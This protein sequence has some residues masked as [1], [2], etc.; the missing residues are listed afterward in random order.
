MQ[1]RQRVA[2]I[3]WVFV[4]FFLLHWI[5]GFLSCAKQSIL[6]L[7]SQMSDVGINSLVNGVLFRKSFPAPTSLGYC[8][9]FL[10]SLISFVHVI[11]IDLIS[12]F[13]TWMFGFPSIIC[14]RYC[15]YSSGFFFFLPLSNIKW[16]RLWVLMLGSLLFYW[17]P[18]VFL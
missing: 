2:P 16:L 8:L 6:V 1:S 18:C 7:K 10:R 11:D 17:S 15:L 13:C 4:F 9:Y 12:F 14:W 5:D 3:L